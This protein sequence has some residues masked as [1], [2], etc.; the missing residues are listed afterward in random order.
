MDKDTPLAVH[1]RFRNTQNANAAP[2]W[3]HSTRPSSFPVSRPGRVVG[4]AALELLPTR[5]L[6][7]FASRLL[8]LRRELRLEL[9]ARF[10]RRRACLLPNIRQ[11]ECLP[12]P[13]RGGEGGS[14]TSAASAARLRASSGGAPPPV[15]LWLSGP[16]PPRVLPGPPT[17]ALLGTGADWGPGRGAAPTARPGEEKWSDSALPQMLPMA[18]RG[19]GDC[20][21]RVGYFMRMLIAD[22]YFIRYW[23]GRA[24]GGDGSCRLG[25]NNGGASSIPRPC[26]GP[27]QAHGGGPHSSN[28]AIGNCVFARPGPISTV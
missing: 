25:E 19:D 23:T 16:P 14:L 26:K 13:V 24:V 8:L 5:I 9:P 12:K 2:G 7:G 22:K 11:W 15:S 28:S 4:F 20:I 27:C 21:G 17:L 10:I 3:Y 18:K 1:L 6:E